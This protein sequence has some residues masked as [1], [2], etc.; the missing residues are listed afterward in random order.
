MCS[1]YPDI[2]APKGKATTKEWHEILSG[3]KVD[4]FGV[5][6]CFDGILD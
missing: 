4:G 3:S 2:Q 6:P 1:L 5:V